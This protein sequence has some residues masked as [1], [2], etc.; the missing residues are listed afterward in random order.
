MNDVLFISILVV[1][2]LSTYGL[3]VV[4]SRLMEG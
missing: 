4:C 1:F 2:F 3:L